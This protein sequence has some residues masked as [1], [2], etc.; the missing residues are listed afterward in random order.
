MEAAGIKMDVSY[1]WAGDSGLLVEIQGTQKYLVST[2]ETHV[3]P[4][5]PPQNHE[6]V[7]VGDPF[8][9]Q[10]QIVM[11]SNYLLK[12]D[13][14]TLLGFR[15]GVGHTFRDALDKTYWGHMEAPVFLYTMA[16]SRDYITHLDT[17][18]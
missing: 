3:P 9:A 13:Y 10:I 16:K 8:Q 6:G 15:K 17:W 4:P 14:H 7:R 2:G 12:E 18:I 11:E 1:A 5:R